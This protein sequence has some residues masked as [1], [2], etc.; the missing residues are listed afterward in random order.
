MGV[1]RLLRV[2]GR[3]GAGRKSG[4]TSPHKA[5]HC[6][7][8][9]QGSPYGMEGAESHRTVERI[10]LVDF[11]KEKQLAVFLISQQYRKLT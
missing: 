4:V 5:G 9:Q 7:N 11:E 6:S 10:S 2:S 8:Q 1:A 3:S